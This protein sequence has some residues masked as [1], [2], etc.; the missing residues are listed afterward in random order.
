MPPAQAIK[1]GDIPGEASDAFKADLYVRTSE[2][3]ELQGYEHYEISNAAQAGFRAVHNQSYWEGREYVGLGPG[4][5]SLEAGQRRANRANLLQWQ[6]ALFEG[7]DPPALIEALDAGMRQREALML[8]LRRRAGVS[9]RAMGLEDQ[10]ALL[11][12]L[13]Q[14]GLAQLEGDLLRLTPRGWLVSDSIVLQLVAA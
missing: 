7:R 11:E 13:E 5:H 12:K 8:G 1:L 14:A 10:G 6:A 4:A 2:W 9:L 3:V